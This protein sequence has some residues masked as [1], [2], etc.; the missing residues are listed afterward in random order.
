M[1]RPSRLLQLSLILSSLLILAPVALA[2]PSRQGGD[3][4]TPGCQWVYSA[5]GAASFTNLRKDSDFTPLG[6]LHLGNGFAAT[7]FPAGNGF[8]DFNGDGVQDVFKVKARPDGLL[9]WQYAPGGVEAWQDL[10]YAS[11]PLANLR[12]GDIDDDGKTDVFAILSQAGGGQQWVY[13]ARGTHS[14]QALKT[15]TADEAAR[16]SAPRLGD[17]NGDGRADVFVAEP[18]PDGAWQ[19]KYAPGGS[20]AFVNLAYAY[21]HPTTL[22]FGDFNADAKT[23]VFAAL[24]Q[25]GGGQQWVFSAG[26]VGNFQTLRTLTAA[27]VAA[28]SLVKVGDFDADG[29]SDIFVAGPRQAGGWQ[30]KVAPQGSGAFVNLAYAFIPPAH[31]RF[32]QFG[33]KGDFS[34]TDVFAVLDCDPT[35]TPTATPTPTSAAT[36]TPTRTL[37]AT[38][39]RT[40]TV[41]PTPTFTATATRTPTVT[42]TPT[43]TA[44]STSTRTATATTAATSTPTRT[45]TAT[46]TPTATPSPTRTP[47]TTATA[48]DVPFPT[49]TPV[50]TLQPAN[51]PGGVR[52]TIQ[53]NPTRAYAGQA[54]AVSGQGAAGYA[55]VRVSS[56]HNGQTVGSTETPVDAQGNY[57]ASLLVPARQPVGITQLCA[58][59]AGA[60]NALLAC[61]DFQVDPMPDGQIQ[62]QIRI[63]P[64]TAVN[65]RVNLVDAAGRL[66]Y[67]APV[68]ASGA[69]QVP[70]AS[71]GLYKAIVTGQTTDPVSPSPVLVMPNRRA[72]V[73]I[74]VNP[75]FRCV[76]DTRTTAYLKL[77][78]DINAAGNENGGFQIVW[79]PTGRLNESEH[80]LKLSEEILAKTQ[81]DHFGVYISGVERTLD[82]TAFPQTATPAHSVIFRLVDANGQVKQEVRVD[83]EPFAAKLAVDRLSP[84]LGS[85][86]PQIQVIPVVKGVEGCPSR[87]PVHMIR[88]PLAHPAVKPLN[89]GTIWQESRQR[90][91]FT[92]I[93]PSVTDVQFFLPPQPLPHFGAFDNRFRAGVVV[94]GVIY[95]S[96][97]IDLTLVRAE[98]LA[99][100]LNVELYN[101]QKPLQLPP[102]HLSNPWQQV[103][104][105][106]L[107]L[108]TFDIVAEDYIGMPFV[109]A[110]VLDLFGLIQ[111]HAASSAGITYGLKMTG[112]VKPFAPEV[113]ARLT[114]TGG[115]QAEVGY[116]LGVI[117]GI[118]AVG[119]TVGLGA[120]LDVPVDVTILP[121]PDVSV[122]EACFR[123]N[124]YARAWAQY[125]W[126]VKIPGANTNPSYVQTI[127]EYPLGCL[128][129]FAAEAAPSEEPPLAPL[130]E[131]FA[132]PSVVSSASGRVLAAYVE[133][134]AAPGATPQ[135][136]IMARF[137]DPTSGQWLA[138]VALSDPAHSAVNPVALFA[139]PQALP[140]V[141]WAEMP[142]DAATAAALGS[143]FNAH[144]RRQEIFYAVFKQE[145]WSTPIRLTDDLI[146]DGLPTAAGGT[147]GAV[148]AWTRDTD[149]DYATRSDQRIAV[150]LFDPA[151]ERFGAVELLCSP[152]GG[153]NNDVRASYDHTGA[154][155]LVWINDAD[156]EF[157]TAADRRLTWARRQQGDWVIEQP[158]AL[159]AGVDS[160]ALSAG[161]DGLQLAFLER[162]AE[163]DGAV[164]LLGPNGAL[165]AAALANGQWQAAPVRDEVGGLV[166]A[167]QPNLA[168][169]QGETL[170][171]FRRFNPASDTNAALG[172]ISMSRA[173]GGGAFTAPIYLTDEPQQN[174]QPALAINPANRQAVILKVARAQNTA[175]AASAKAIA[176]S[177]A[178]MASQGST[179][180][181]AQDPVEAVVAIAAADP[182][183]D[184][185]QATAG[186]LPAGEPI[187]VTVTVRNVGRDPALDVDLTLY[188]GV[189]GSAAVLATRE[190]AGPLALNATTTHNFVV[191]AKGGEMPLFAEVTTSGGN[192]TTTNDRVFLVVGAPSTPTIAGVTA[193][194]WTPD[195]FDIA[196]AG[197]E[198]E[199]PAG[200]RVLR[201]TTPDGLY[202]L[203]GESAVAG[204]TDTLAQRG[205]TYC[206]RVQA[207]N[208][209]AFSP[210]SEAVCGQ[211]DLLDTFL[212]IV[213]R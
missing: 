29:H 63:N 85:Q 61:T 150:T 88:N 16:Y 166:F 157:T 47:A 141:A 48:T 171:V 158:Q 62:G 95:E 201:S 46:A 42:P 204:Y 6:D 68:S 120:K 69:F 99:K 206:Y 5:G 129:P 51:V 134:R 133:N 181:A 142:Y 168:F 106:K 191:A 74:S 13:S 102:K 97:K 43:P 165:W 149:A 143:D 128:G 108:G 131:L 176:A 50:P 185:L 30:W 41:T 1:L 93:F 10:A 160:P 21:P 136:Q 77:T 8:T 81:R 82:F 151:S 35:P 2:A 192:A 110:P 109:H 78:S 189:P 170:L 196:W 34:T 71:P 114:A 31:L 11:V 27:E 183:L 195:A 56:I 188:Q 18:R 84:S 83:G 182:A 24:S 12:F 135:V 156:A 124:A 59:V 39:T 212:P 177:Q 175:S 19:W 198:N 55:L 87:Y 210:L 190:L 209:G 112:W 52:V 163:A 121:K 184:P 38:S 90:Y 111:V 64:G 44:T 116:G 49:D 127:A 100:A 72:D 80:L 167:E 205:L 159:P 66:R 104:G 174:W 203:I 113:G 187:T 96:G 200:Y 23:D 75:A 178:I 123:L 3:L 193:S 17:F 213:T 79:Q 101:R 130:P 117:A 107:D 186:V 22:Q 161:P 89:G 25:A 9:Q 137:Q 37:T 70:S 147:T 98:V 65:A 144:L 169:A 28:Y 164:P 173:Q 126:G 76:V 145:T 7:S 194:T 15:L 152:A 60:A 20:G 211:L 53:V 122:P 146:I 154:A 105:W 14:F 119:Y 138:P 103:Q 92:G 208:G 36:S 162:Q 199:R 54:V 197:A 140:V 172:Q 139:G 132:S 155:H 40:P 86:H 4:P 58:S 33:S 118:A 67:V 45:P 94:G 57:S 32:G 73:D 179:L 153:M 26:G 202:E 115:A 207:H 148:L 91:E 125:L 180:A